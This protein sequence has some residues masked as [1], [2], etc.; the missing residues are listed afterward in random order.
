[1]YWIGGFGDRAYIGW[2]PVDEWKSVS[3]EEWEDIRLPGEWE[4]HGPPKHHEKPEAPEDSGDEES[5]DEEVEEKEKGWVVV[6][7]G[8]NEGYTVE[9]L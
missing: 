2:I 8:K 9:D 7:D 5:E 3:K 6:Q 1:M 4:H